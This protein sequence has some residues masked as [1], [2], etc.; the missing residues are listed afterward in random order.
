MRSCSPVESASISRASRHDIAAAFEGLQ[1]DTD[2]NARVE[3]G[4]ISAAG[5]RVSAWVVHAREDLVLLRETLRLS[6]A[7]HRQPAAV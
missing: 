7:I 4:A 5:S 6:A 1:I 2:A 3:E